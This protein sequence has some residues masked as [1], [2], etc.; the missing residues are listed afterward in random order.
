MGTATWCGPCQRIAPV[1]VKF[2]EE[3]PD[4]VF[5]KVDVDENEET[6]AACNI[7]C[8]PTFQ[9]Y[10]SGTK[11]HERT[12]KMCL[13]VP[14]ATSRISCDGDPRSHDSEPEP[15]CIHL[16]HRKPSTSRPPPSDILARAR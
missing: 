10:K 15:C 8:M 14:S 11:V 6:A 4:V 5:V 16:A 9:M 1:F 3:M 2:A 12:G 13:A 7:S